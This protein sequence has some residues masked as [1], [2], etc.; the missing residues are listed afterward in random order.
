MNLA[1][2]IYPVQSSTEF[3]KKAVISVAVNRAHAVSFESTILGNEVT[4]QRNNF[5]CSSNR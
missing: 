1:E 3:D 4:S 2:Q 5:V